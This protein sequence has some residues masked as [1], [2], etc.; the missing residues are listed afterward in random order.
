MTNQKDEIQLAA[1]WF[2]DL[3]QSKLKA[4]EHGNLLQFLNRS[5]RSQQKQTLNRIATATFENAAKLVLEDGF[6]CFADKENLVWIHKFKERRKF[7]NDI[8]KELN[9]K[10]YSIISMDFTIK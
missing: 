3:I 4:T 9:K 7:R 5:N 10:G 8:I 6:D 1:S 2:E